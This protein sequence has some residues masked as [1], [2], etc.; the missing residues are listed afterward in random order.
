MANLN[1]HAV[2]PNELSFQ[3]NMAE[4]WAFFSQKFKI[5]LKASN[6]DTETEDNKGYILLNRIGDRAL[7]IYNN[8][9]WRE[10]DD[11]TKC[12]KILKK[13]G[14]YFTPT[15]NVTYER[16][17]FFTR[18]KKEDESYDSYV[19]ELRQ[20]ASSCEFSTLT[21]SLIRDR[22]ILGI[23][24]TAMKERLLREADIDL[25]KALDVCRAAE[26]ATGRLQIIEGDKRG[27]QHEVHAVQRGNFQRRE[28]NPS[29][30]TAVSG[31]NVNQ[32]KFQN[33]RNYER[34]QK[35]STFN[36]NSNSKFVKNCLRCGQNHKINACPAYGKKCDSCKKL[37][38]FS[39]VCK[40][41]QFVNNINNEFRDIP[42]L[43]MDELTIY[44][45]VND[46]NSTDSNRWFEN[47]YVNNKLKVQFRL[48][49][50]A[51]ISIL[52]YNEFMKLNI[53][54]GQLDKPDINLVS[55]NGGKIFSLGTVTLNIKRCNAKNNNATVKFNIVRTSKPPLL[56][57]NACEKL[58]LLQRKA[59]KSS[60]ID[61]LSRN[62]GCETLIDKY[63]DVFQGIGCLPGTYNIE[64]DESVPP[65]IHPQR[66]V[67]YALHQPLKDKL[68]QL[69]KAQIVRKVNEPTDWVNSL[70]I[71]R[72][73]NNDLRLCIDPKDLNLAIKREHF[74]IP[75]LD[76][77]ISNLKDAKYFS[78]LDCSN[79]FWQIKLNE[80]SSKLTTFNTPWGRYRFLRLPYGISSA[81]EV[82]MKRLREI[83]DT[84]EGIGMYVDDILVY[85]KTLE[86]HKVK[87]NKLFQVARENNVKFNK[88]KCKF[89]V[90]SVKYMGFNLSSKGLEID[91]NKVVAI[92]N[93]QVP[94]CAK[95]IERFLGIVNYVSRFIP[96]FSDVTE[97]LRSLVKKGVKFLWGNK[98]EKSFQTLKSLLMTAPVLQFY[99]S[100]LPV[101]ISCDAS[102]NGCGSVLL[103][104]NA[105]VSYASK[106]FTPTQQKYAQIEKELLS[107]CH[108]CTK[109][110]NYIYGRSD[111]TIETDHKPLIN[112]FK[113]PLLT[114]PA[115]LQRM[116]L[117]LQPYSF[118]LIYKPGKEL[119]LADA[120]SRAYQNDYDRN[121]ELKCTEI[122]NHLLF[123]TKDMPVSSEKF[124]EFERETQRDA[125]LQG[126]IE[127][128]TKGFPREKKFLKDEFKIYWQH[129]DELYYANGIIF[130]NNRIFVP[131]SLRKEMLARLHVA[132]LGKVKTKLNAKQLLF[133]PAMYADI[134]NL[135]ESCEACM[136]NSNCN[137]KEPL[138]SYEVPYGAWRKVGTDIFSFIND[139]Y[140]ITV[141][142][143]SKFV[144]VQKL[145]AETSQCVINA[146][147]KLFSIHGIPDSLV[148]DNGPCFNSWEFKKFC[149]DWKI[150][151]IK[152]SPHYPQ[153][154]GQVERFV[155]TVK[156]TFKKC[157]QSGD[158]FDLALL[159]IRNTPIASDLPSPAQLMFSRRLK[160]LIPVKN[161][162]LKPKVQPLSNTRNKLRDRQNR[163][164][165]Y[166]D[167]NS[168]E[169]SNLAPGTIV[170]VKS[171]QSNQR[172]K[173]LDGEVLEKN[174]TPRSYKV[175]LQTGNIVNRNRKH[176]IVN[177]GKDKLNYPKI[178]N[179]N[180]FKYDDIH[181]Q[182][183][184]M[185]HEQ[186]SDH[187]SVNIT[188]P[189]S[190]NVSHFSDSESFFES[191]ESLDSSIREMP[192]HSPVRTRLGRTVRPP[193][194]LSF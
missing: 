36:N 12:Q 184:N 140:L 179:Y 127:I 53:P 13:F 152:T 58:N 132:H 82:F 158:D 143:Y 18:N 9:S 63:S 87:L 40:Q 185:R 28:R 148:S 106:A 96:S 115:R 21:D 67:P 52:P 128:I 1:E 15:K 86:E 110:H 66:K 41:K 80:R 94:S 186:V 178:G 49:T 135:I 136:S 151:S 108:A 104:N 33:G 139:K 38:H 118:N 22:L 145:S 144:E 3:G 138:M 29:A 142:Y 162:L 70:V 109:F 130:K 101:I 141:D 79:G 150:R 146:L 102:Q 125:H 35:I 17:L 72:K 55:Y 6:L 81:S 32:P 163:Q 131:K 68:Q 20:L 126:L 11:K 39:R 65:R 61:L 84:V 27:H 134:N 193:I 157:S 156:N 5:Y 169:L 114:A 62:N 183:D 121:F 85:S 194:R 112:I 190:R 120:L 93:I 172:Y 91:E 129:K 192:R 92:K 64:L 170:K 50:G 10:T 116:L 74:Y 98:Q 119:L 165:V 16:Y 176:M 159:Q 45:L 73:S 24:D 54:I 2:P 34:K 51:D 124:E 177:K 173:W 88:D 180:C 31:R 191:S 171:F 48:D 19:T 167:K 26:T 7:K 69:E 103:Q 107:I 155:Q 97:P 42:E 189:S 160:T 76:D 77:I 78:V 57:G 149:L 47:L 37:N 25:N 75:N 137:Q 164:K 23:T 8:F 117:M 122:E 90:D 147:K 175:K 188:S 30:V 168:K 14:E 4:N 154:N 89:C 56:D 83:F 60:S 105:P 181:P 71:V 95:D 187:G 44:N 111:V 123:I 59:T 174:N 182:N 100:S 46:E 166:F 161:S 153:S 43:P 113:K 133:W 99:S